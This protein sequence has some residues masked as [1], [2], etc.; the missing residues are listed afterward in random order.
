MIF[1]AFKRMRE[2][3]PGDPAFLVASGDRSLPINWRQ[4]TDD[5]DLVVR[6]V[7]QYAQN[8]KVM[9]L[10]ENSYEWVVA[11]AA[12]V[13]AGATVLPT[14]VNLSAQEIADRIRFTGASVLVYSALHSEKAHE[15]RALV[16]GLKT[17]GFGSLKTERFLDGVRSL[18][19]PKDSVWNNDSVDTSR[20][21]TIV[22]TSGTTTVPR[23]AELTIGGIEACVEAWGAAL[24]VKPGDRTLMLL[25]LHHIYGL[26]ATYLF[27]ARGAAL[28]VCPDFRRLYDAVER[29]RVNYVALVPALADI[30]A[31]KIEHRGKSA[32]EA[33]GQPLDWVLAGGAP[34]P[35]L[36]YER[37]NALGIRTLTAYGLT[38]TT[39]LYAIEPA[40][41]P[42]H[43]CSAGKVP[44]CRG[45]ETKVGEG[46]ELLIRGPCVMKGY[47]REPE[48]TAAVIDADGWFHTGD[49]GRIDEEGYVWITG[50]AS[51]TI[52][53]SSGKK[54]APEELEAMLI[55]IPGVREALV[56]GD[57][58][59]R[60]VKAEVY[61][62]IPEESIRRAVDELNQRLPVYKRI[63]SLVVR[64]EPF[65]RTSSGKIRVSAAR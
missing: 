46:G 33:L 36:V 30:L 41:D 62:M 1:E 51:R 61:G 10:G 20:V 29:F 2:E 17:G 49:V 6:L 59:T 44:D 65:E 28:G 12:V 22:F 25:P 54:I 15:V 16:P 3:R 63:S 37:L 48:C 8:E 4:F 60:E 24:P 57:A 18:F 21:S 64:S 38:E 14:D 7:G 55:G 31:Q 9:L 45:V 34:L 56:S 26:C 5:I 42:S 19:K 35:R 52:V 32:E 47:F 39:A 58:Q 50:R 23:G 40:S 53:L 43:A 13:F 27:L 11:H